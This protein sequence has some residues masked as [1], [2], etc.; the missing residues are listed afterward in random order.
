[1]LWHQAVNKGRG[2]HSQAL[3]GEIHPP[4][5]G[6]IK[7]GMYHVNSFCFLTEILSTHNP[8]QVENQRKVKKRF[9]PP[10]PPSHFF[11]GTVNEEQYRLKK[12][13]GFCKTAAALIKC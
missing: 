1:M 11:L 7:T 12:A 10:T 8:K 5:V 4:Q 13:H 3:L 6:L 2:L 9:F